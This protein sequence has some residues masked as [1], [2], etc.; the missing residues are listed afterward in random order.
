VGGATLLL[1]PTV[2]FGVRNVEILDS[3]SRVFFC[4]SLRVFL[5]LKSVST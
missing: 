1:G 3:A 2:G 5:H 4:L